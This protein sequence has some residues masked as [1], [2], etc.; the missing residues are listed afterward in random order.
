MPSAPILCQTLE[1]LKNLK[2]TTEGTSPRL[3]LFFLFSFFESRSWKLLVDVSGKWLFKQIL[4]YLLTAY[5][6]QLIELSDIRR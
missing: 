1:T 5:R 4:H 2:N 6:F 3:R